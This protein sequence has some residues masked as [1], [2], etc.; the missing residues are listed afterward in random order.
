MRKRKSPVGC[1]QVEDDRVRVGDLDPGDRLALPRREALDHV[2]VERVLGSVSRVRDPLHRSHD[3]LRGDLAVHRWR[4]LDP[5][6]QVERVRLAAVRDAAVRE[7]RNDGR[8]VGNGN[9]ARAVRDVVVADERAGEQA[10]CDSE[11]VA[12][13]LA[14]RVEVVGGAERLLPAVDER[15]AGRD[16]VLR[17]PGR[18]GRDDDRR[19][20]DARWPRSRPAYA[21]V[22]SRYVSPSLPRAGRRGDRSDQEPC[23]D[24]NTAPLC[25]NGPPAHRVRRGGRLRED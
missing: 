22:Y 3:V 16:M 8:D 25:I 9:V 13:V 5:V 15:A 24:Q 19:S 21:M 6:L 18:A 1:R 7:R 2:V 20:D 12:E 14:G 4:E 23:D 17:L 10:R 11:P